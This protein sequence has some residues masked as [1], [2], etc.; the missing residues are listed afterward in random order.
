M[1]IRQRIQAKFV[2]VGVSAIAALLVF[3][4]TSPVLG[5][6]P[7][8]EVSAKAYRYA[9]PL[10]QIPNLNLPQLNNFL[11]SNSRDRAVETG[12]VDLDGNQLFAIATP[13]TTDGGNNPIDQRVATIENNLEQ[14]V[15]SNYDRLEVTTQIDQS[16]GLPIISVNNR[17]LMTVTTLDAQIHGSNPQRL[18]NEYASI[19]KTSLQKAKRERQPK[20][21]V[22]QGIIAGGIVV[23]AIVLSSVFATW[24]RRYQRQKQR[25]E[26]ETPKNP[27]DPS[28]SSEQ[29]NADTELIVQQQLIK[30]RQRNSSDLKRRLLH[31][32]QVGIWGGSIYII[33][34]LFPY[35]R[36]L[37]PF[38][39]STP[40]QILGIGIGTYSNCQ[41]C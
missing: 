9:Y 31:L 3:F 24:Q 32:G 5:Q 4:S 41:G 21:L 34:E 40:L 17:Y 6:T 36:W 15:S 18:A 25:I 1:R 8:H 35:T 19:V 14:I 33:L 22:R 7:R 28:Q 26:A 27:L 2:T 38:I 29:L 13:I 37:Q 16:S 12:T 39:V 11:L 10:G 30:Q 23:G 20:F